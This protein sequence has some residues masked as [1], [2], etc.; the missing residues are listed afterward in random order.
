M[1]LEKNN[2]HNSLIGIIDTANL[3]IEVTILNQF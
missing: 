2:H 3:R 1:P